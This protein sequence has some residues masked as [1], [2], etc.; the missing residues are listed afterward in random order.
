LRGEVDELF[1]SGHDLAAILEDV[2]RVSVRLMLQIA[3]EAE[4]D[5]ILG[6][7]RYQRREQ[8]GPAGS[9]NG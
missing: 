7:M 1:A 9:R 8:D 2:A 4:V 3:L 6:C 5:A